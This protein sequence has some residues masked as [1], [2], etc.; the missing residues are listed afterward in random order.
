MQRFILVY[1]NYRHIQK[2]RFA[3]YVSLKSNEVRQTSVPM[4]VNFFTGYSNLLLGFWMAHVPRSEVTV[5][6]PCNLERRSPWENKI[7]II[8]LIAF[9]DYCRN[10][11]FL[12]T[13]LNGVSRLSD[14]QWVEMTFDVGHCPFSKVHFTKLFR[15]N[16]NAG[17]KLVYSHIS[18]R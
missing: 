4:V 3:Y 6:G 7:N 10:D 2:V 14:S 13:F 5:F 9:G 11:L 17:R 8:E 12:Y 1:R 18:M 16:I 15:V